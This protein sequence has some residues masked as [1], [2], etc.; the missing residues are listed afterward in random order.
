MDELLWSSTL[1]I[2]DYHASLIVANDNL[3]AAEFSHHTQTDY[4]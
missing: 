3:A 2:S 1:F 4:V